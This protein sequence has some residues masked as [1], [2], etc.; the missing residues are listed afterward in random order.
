MNPTFQPTDED[1]EID[2]DVQ[3]IADNL[4]ALVVLRNACWN[5][6]WRGEYHLCQGLLHEM[7]VLVE[8][9]TPPDSP[10]GMIASAMM[11]ILQS[12]NDE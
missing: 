10:A 2:P 7:T 8:G 9:E 3:V 5:L 12:E 4:Q 11:E 1:R 6:G